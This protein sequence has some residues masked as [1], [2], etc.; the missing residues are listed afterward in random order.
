M[1]GLSPVHIAEI[2][3][4]VFALLLFLGT[5]IMVALGV[6]AMA[7]FVMVGTNLN[8]MIQ[9]AVSSLTSFPLM[10]L[11]CFVLAGALMESAGISK[12]LV[13]I[14]ENIVGPI[15]P[16]A[17]PYPRPF[18]VCSSGPFPDPA[19]PPRPLWAC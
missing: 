16:A 8:N 10:A 4:A 6:A 18:S 17:W 14:A 1:T 11:P 12:R 15:P 2:L 5:P 9:M 19:R 13:H 3:F 7:V